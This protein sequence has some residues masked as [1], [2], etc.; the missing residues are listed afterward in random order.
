MMVQ[1]QVFKR[2]QQSKVWKEEYIY[3]PLKERS[4]LLLAQVDCISVDEEYTVADV[5]GEYSAA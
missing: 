1:E 5:A 2:S 3:F 4:I